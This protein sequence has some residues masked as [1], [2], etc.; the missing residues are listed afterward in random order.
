M[1]ILLLN[2]VL[3]K[4]ICDVVAIYLRRT[5]PFVLYDPQFVVMKGLDLEYL[6]NSHGQY[7]FKM[8]RDSLFST[9]RFLD[10]HAYANTPFWRNMHGDLV[11]AIDK[12][13]MA[14][15][16]KGKR[17]ICDVD[18]APTVPKNMFREPPREAFIAKKRIRDERN[19]F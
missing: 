13:D 15:Y 10:F 3:P 12:V 7:I 8:V 1:A 11:L 2:K 9:Q 19:G 14:R 16:T 17:Y 4:E 18:C 5:R 6:Y